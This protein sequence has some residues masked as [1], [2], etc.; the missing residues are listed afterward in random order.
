MFD[1]VFLAVALLII[2]VA[3]FSRKASSPSRAERIGAAGEDRVH[4]AVARLGLPILSDLYVPHNGGTSQI[5]HVVCLGGFLAVIETK[6]YSGEI[7]AADPHAPY[8]VVR[9]G[10][11]E[12]RL[13]NPLQQNWGHIRALKA[14]HSDVWMENI[15][16][17]AGDAVWCVPM[18]SG[19]VEIGDLAE[20]LVTRRKPMA[21]AVARAWKSLTA[22]EADG[23]KHKDTL[24]RAHVQRIQRKRAA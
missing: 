5:D 23:R 24:R 15:V 2:A 14:H 11:Q 10:N 21:A 12:H 16:V 18:P 3:L 6:T 22:L 13:D 8:W 9:Y 17:F 19:V 20:A 4:Q 7:I 1:L